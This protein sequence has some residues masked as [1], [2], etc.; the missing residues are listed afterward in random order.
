MR[1]LMRQNVAQV[2]H[3]KPTSALT[4]LHEVLGFIGWSW[5]DNN[6]A[7]R[8]QLFLKVARRHRVHHVRR[9]M[10]QSERQ[11][12]TTARAVGSDV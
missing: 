12:L 9:R 3:I 2:P 5:A 4:T 10:R 7:R 6:T 11:T 8:P 1:P